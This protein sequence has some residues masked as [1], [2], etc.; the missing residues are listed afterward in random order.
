MSTKEYPSYAALGNP[1]SRTKNQKS[2]LEK[3]TASVILFSG[4]ISSILLSHDK[5][6]KIR[7]VYKN[8]FIDFNL[9]I[10]FITLLLKVKSNS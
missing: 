1:N 7:R 3:I 9:F 5:K 2:L 6:E 4:S 10:F 8:N